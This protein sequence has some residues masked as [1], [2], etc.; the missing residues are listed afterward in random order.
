M[1]DSQ[2]I[3]MQGLSSK[4]CERVSSCCRQPGG[5]G[6]EARPVDRITHQGVADRGEVDSD[7]VGPP[8]LQLTGEKARDRLAVGP[9]EGLK[10][11]PM[12]NGLAAILPHRHL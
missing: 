5:L 6:L 10:L 8:G 11:L 7:L 1:Y 4:G 12:G 3:S 2:Q 9:R